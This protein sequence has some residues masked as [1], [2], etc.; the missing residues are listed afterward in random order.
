VQNHSRFFD[1]E[2][3]EVNLPLQSE[4]KKRK[5][6]VTENLEDSEEDNPKEDTPK[7]DT[8]KEDNPEEENPE[9]DTPKTWTI[10][11]ET[12]EEHTISIKTVTGKWIEMSSGA[13]LK[14]VENQTPEQVVQACI[15]AGDEASLV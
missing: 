12:G 2:A 14:I 11:D 3:E 6:V 1:D 9:E 4:K 10:K 5:I 7:E 13:R 8:P 15:D